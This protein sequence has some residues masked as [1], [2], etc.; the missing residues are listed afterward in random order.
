MSILTLEEIHAVC[1]DPQSERE[2][3]DFAAGISA[4]LEKACNRVFAKRASNATAVNGTA[5]AKVLRHGLRVG[6]SIKVA[7]I[8][9]ASHWDGVTTVASVTGYDELTFEIDSELASETAAEI[10]IRPVRSNVMQTSGGSILMLHPRPV[11]E[12]TSVEIGLGDGTYETALASTAYALGDQIDGVSYSGELVLY[13]ELFPKRLGDYRGGHLQTSGAR[14]GYVCGEPIVPPDLV[15][16]AQRAMKSV[17]EKRL[18]KN[19]DLQSESYDYY[20]YSRMGTEQLR[21]M[22]GEFESIIRSHR[23]ALI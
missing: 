23:L 19:T 5:S 9:A 10:S 17:W 7:A 15:Y 22:F 6:Q 14:V 11:A 3:F 4:A 16:G 8:N 21:D 13:T 20:S 18:K 2:L 12:I 1:R